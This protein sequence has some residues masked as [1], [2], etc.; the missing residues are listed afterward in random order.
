MFETNRQRKKALILANS[1]TRALFYLIRVLI[2]ILILF[3]IFITV[4]G[5]WCN[6]KEEKI[7]EKLFGSW[8]IAVIEVEENQLSYFKKNAFINNYAVQYIQEKNYL[9]NDIRI[10]IG[11]CEEKFL[12]IASIKLLNGRTFFIIPHYSKTA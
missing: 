2:I 9:N 11:S 1:E 4:F 3:T 8:N 12:D 6:L 10:V 5:K 7:K